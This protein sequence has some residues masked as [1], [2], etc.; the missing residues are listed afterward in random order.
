MRQAVVKNMALM[1]CYHLCNS[2]Q[3]TQRGGIQDS[4]IVSLG[5]LAIIAGLVFSNETVFATWRD[6]RTIGQ[7]EALLGGDYFQHFL[8]QAHRPMGC[9]LQSALATE[10]QDGRF[11]GRLIHVRLID[12]TSC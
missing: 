12:D 10:P 9:N 7:N 11:C 6:D 2:A 1:G 3:S 8:R 5:R 4:V